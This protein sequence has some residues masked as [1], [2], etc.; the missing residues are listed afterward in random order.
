MDPT[1]PDPSVDASVEHDLP[2]VND[3]VLLEGPW[4]R[5]F[6]VRAGLPLRSKSNFRRHHAGGGKATWG[7]TRDFERSLGLLLRGLRPAG[8]VVG[9][10]GQPVA[11]RPV[12]VAVIGARSSLDVANYS[13]SV[14][15]AGEGVL[16][17]SDASVLAVGSIGTRGRGEETLVAFAQLAAGAGPAVTAAALGALTGHVATLLD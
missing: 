17:V 7:D 6:L 12:I 10:R 11:A 1:S 15:D 9:E 5:G 16:Y 2:P 13:K 3:I 14:L 4:Q 8:W